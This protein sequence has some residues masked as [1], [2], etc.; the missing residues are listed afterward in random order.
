[1]A[2]FSDF[3]YTF[4]QIHER[5]PDL[6]IRSSIPSK[7]GE[8][9]ILFLTYTFVMF[10]EY[11]YDL[12]ENILKKKL[13]RI[14]NVYKQSEF[15][16]QQESQKVRANIDLTLFLPLKSQ[17]LLYKIALY[18]IKGYSDLMTFLNLLSSRP[19]SRVSNRDLNML[20]TILAIDIT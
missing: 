10:V 18:E 7:R 3:K 20:I 19:P 8:E 2:R 15:L 13:I 1:M 16:P 4:L 14:Q 5:K 17:Y 11:A 9:R 12:L 6:D